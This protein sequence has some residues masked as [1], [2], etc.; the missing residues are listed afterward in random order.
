MSGIRPILTLKLNEI[1][2]MTDE[3]EINNVEVSSGNIDSRIYNEQTNYN[4]NSSS[5]SRY[6]KSNGNS[7]SSSKN[8]II[9]GKT[10]VDSNVI[11]DDSVSNSNIENMEPDTTKNDDN[12]LILH[13]TFIIVFSLLII[14]IV[15]AIVYYSTKY[16]KD[17]NKK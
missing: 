6:E 5:S 4:G 12:K 9:N 7:D 10:D 16:D 11:N 8:E 13:Y 14:V 15:I 3:E 1:E 2:K 17:V